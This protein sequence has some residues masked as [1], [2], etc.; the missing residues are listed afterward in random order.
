MGIDFGLGVR[1]SVRVPLAAAQDGGLDNPSR[2]LASAVRESAHDHKDAS[3]S[4]RAVHGGRGFDDYRIYLGN[5][6]RPGS[7]R[8]G[9]ESGS[10][11]ASGSR[12]D[13]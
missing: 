2:R 12:R 10:L 1:V 8:P 7:E 11:P 4:R 13:P 6:P 5:Q 3:F 9:Y